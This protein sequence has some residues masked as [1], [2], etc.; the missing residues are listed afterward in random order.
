MEQLNVSAVAVMVGLADTLQ[1]RVPLP[2][3]HHLHAAMKNTES[4]LSKLRRQR[5]LAGFNLETVMRFMT[6]YYNMREVAAELIGM[7]DRAGML[8]EE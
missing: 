7:A 1:R 5:T 3:V 8:K 2:P 4:A 6:F